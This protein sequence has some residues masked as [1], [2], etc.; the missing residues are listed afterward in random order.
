[1]HVLE[2]SIRKDDFSSFFIENMELQRA[3]EAIRNRDQPPNVMRYS[4]GGIGSTEMRRRDDLEAMQRTR[5]VSR[6][7]RGDFLMH[8][9]WPSCIPHHRVD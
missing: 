8:P 2:E 4:R 5:Y 7:S 6:P 9:D 1:M 3:L